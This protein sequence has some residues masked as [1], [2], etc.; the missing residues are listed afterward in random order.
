M[1]GCTR[2]GAGRGVPGWVYRVGR[3]G[4][5]PVPRPSSQDPYLVIFLRL[6][7]YPRPYDWVYGCFYE[8]SQTGSRIGSWN[9]LRIDQN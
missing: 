9:D 1:E 4:A 2:G 3:E 7:P 8:V 6:G 5:I